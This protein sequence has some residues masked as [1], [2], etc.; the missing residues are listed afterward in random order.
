MAVAS[1]P[2]QPLNRSTA[3]SRHRPCSNFVHRAQ[4]GDAC[5]TWCL[6]VAGG[7]PPRVVIDQRAGL[8]LVHVE[9]LLDGGFAVIITLDQRFTGEVVLA[10]HFWRVE[11]QVIAAARRLMHTPAKPA[12]S[13]GMASRMPPS[14]PCRFYK[15]HNP[16]LK[17]PA[18]WRCAAQVEACGGLPWAKPLPTCATNGAIP[19]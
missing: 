6:S 12:S 13:R 2:A 1:Q 10:G 18:Y 8:R 15:N 7:S 17:P 4:A 5:I 9:A 19:E 16:L 3:Q 11:L 14:C